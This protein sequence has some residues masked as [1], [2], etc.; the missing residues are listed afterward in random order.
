MVSTD[1]VHNVPFAGSV[2]FV[3]VSHREPCLRMSPT[4]AVRRAN[5]AVGAP[6]NSVYKLVVEESAIF[7]DRF[8]GC[9]LVYFKRL[10]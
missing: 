10:V 9:I 8:S 6:S 5:W 4:L 3:H 1:F 7:G 2:A